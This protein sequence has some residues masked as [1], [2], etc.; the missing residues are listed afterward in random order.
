MAM[1]RPFGNGEL[2]LAVWG[3]NCFGELRGNKGFHVSQN[4]SKPLLR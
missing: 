4:T 1:K 3:D 2:F